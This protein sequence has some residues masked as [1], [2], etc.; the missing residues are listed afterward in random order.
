L[1]RPFPASLRL[2]PADWVRI[3]W[4]PVCAENRQWLLGGPVVYDVRL[5]AIQQKCRACGDIDDLTA[6]LHGRR[7]TDHNGEFD[8]GMA[9]TR[10][11]RSRPDAVPHGLEGEHAI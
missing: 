11:A 3:Q 4:H 8:L 2:F 5:L 1:R 7:A 10:A 9:V 6:S